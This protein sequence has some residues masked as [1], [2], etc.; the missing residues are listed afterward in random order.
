MAGIGTQLLIEFVQL[1]NEL[2]Q[3]SITPLAIDS[4]RALSRPIVSNDSVLPPTELFSTRHEVERANSTRLASLQSPPVTFD[5]RDSG[6][7]APEKRKAVLANMRVPE[8]LILKK[9]AQVMLVKNIDDQRGL[10][11]GAVGRVLGFFAAPR[12]KS[13]GVITNVEISE[14]GKSVVFA[15]EAKENLKPGSTVPVKTPNNEGKKPA[16]GATELFP[17]VEFPTPTGKERTLVTR[18]EFRIEDNEGVVLARRVQACYPVVLQLPCSITCMRYQ[19]PLIL[20][21]AISIHKSQGQTIQR[22]KVDLGRVFEKGQ[23]YVALSR[24]ATMDGLQV[25]RFD[26]KKVPFSFCLR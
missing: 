5:A 20:A 7:A 25:L 4:F 19:V 26:P 3:G 18:D 23:S 1:L 21:W 17:L 22:V 15:G 10:V 2:R 12:G 8:R 14:D 6:S 13:E 9:G 16:T 11:N 24:A